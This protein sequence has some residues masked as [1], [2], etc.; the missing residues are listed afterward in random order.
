MSLNEAYK[1]VEQAISAL[2]VNPHECRGE[3]A[4]AWSIHK[5][6]YELWIDVWEIEQE[7]RPY[8]Q[9]MAP[10]AKVPS[11]VSPA[12]YRELLELNQQLFAVAFAIRDGDLVLRVIRETAGLDADEA[13]AMITRVGNY[14][15]QHGSKLVEKYFN[16][17]GPGPV[18]DL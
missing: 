18:S 12:F 9:V 13:L 10:I 3:E 8:F 17:K 2:G 4:G 14:A 5:D 7:N 6:D 16:N 1:I 15:V 11:D